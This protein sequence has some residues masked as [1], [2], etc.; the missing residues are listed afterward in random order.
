MLPKICPC[1]TPAV[2][3]MVSTSAVVPYQD[4]VGNLH[5]TW[6]RLHVCML[7]WAALHWCGLCLP[8]M[9]QSLDPPACVAAEWCQVRISSHDNLSFTVCSVVLAYLKVLSEPVTWRQAKEHLKAWSRLRVWWWTDWCSLLIE[10][11]CAKFLSN[12]SGE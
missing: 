12:D 1:Y 6:Q 4:S 11:P 7:L 10:I 9:P 8:Q 5:T 2:W 3:L